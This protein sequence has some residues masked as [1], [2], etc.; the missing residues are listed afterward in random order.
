MDK[1]QSLI[2]R[3]TY[4]RIKKMDRQEMD[5]FLFHLVEDYYKEGMK[6]GNEISASV[7]IRVIISEILNKTKGVGPVMYDRIMEV[8]KKHL[9]DR[10][11]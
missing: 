11:N 6:A 8:A 4:K 3:A 9:E 1:R 2:N 5:A 7:D 10:E